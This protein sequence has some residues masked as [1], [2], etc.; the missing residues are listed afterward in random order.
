MPRGDQLGRQWR[1]LQLLGKPQGLA[2]DERGALGRAFRRLCCLGRDGGVCPV[3]E[4]CPCH[5]IFETAPPPDAEALST[6]EGIPRPFVI[7]PPPASATDYPP[8]SVVSFDL[9]LVGHA[10]QYLPH[11]VV[12]FRDMDRIGRGRRRVKLRRLESVHPLTGVTEAVYMAESNLVTPS[13]PRFVADEPH[14]AGGVGGPG[15]RRGRTGGWSGRGSSVRRCT[16]GI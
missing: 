4:S 11:F 15:T 2:V 3:P 12:T 9:T 16:R 14:R 8:G 7:A 10:R 5:L 13:P 1:L 6:H